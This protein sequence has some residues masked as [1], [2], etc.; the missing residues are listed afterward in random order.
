[1]RIGVTGHQNIP[2]AALDYITRGIKSVLDSVRNNLVGIS[3]LAAGADQLFASHVLERG[4]RLEVILP[5]SAYEKTF[6]RLRDLRN[7]R[8]LL[9]RAAMVEQLSFE[10][11]SADAYLTAGRRVVELSELLLAIWDGEP[12]KGTGG[13]ADI[14][15]YARSCGTHV[16]LVWPRGTIR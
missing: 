4:G 2:P 9:D 6:S 7:F 15:E 13:T 16:E 8:S 14:V 10:A 12:A 3:S 1:M 5:C 11:P